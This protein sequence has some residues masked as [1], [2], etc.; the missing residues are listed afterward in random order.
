VSRSHNRGSAHIDI[1]S[2]NAVLCPDSKYIFVT[3]LVDGVD[4]YT[5]PT[6]ERVQ[7]FSHNVVHNYPLQVATLQQASFV[8]AGGDNGFARIFERR[9]GQLL[10]QLK[11]GDDGDPVQV[12]AVSSPDC[13]IGSSDMNTSTDPLGCEVLP[14]CHGLLRWYCR[15]LHQ[16]LD[17]FPPAGKL[18]CPQSRL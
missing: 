2:G 11:H 15:R 9:N 14:D 17:D 1:S 13:W 5:F 10:S 16:N 4:Q 7:T 8:V 6:L 3:N 12:V 18:Y